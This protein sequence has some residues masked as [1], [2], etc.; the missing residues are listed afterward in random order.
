MTSAD[1]PLGMTL[2]QQAGWNQ[3]RAD[4]CRFLTLGPGGCFA[5]ELNGRPVGTVSTCILGGV[6]WIGMLLVSV[7]VRGRGVG[8]QLMRHALNHLTDRQVTSI[9]LDATPLGQPIYE[10]LGFQPQYTLSRFAGKPQSRTSQSRAQRM[11]EQHERAV[12]ELDAGVV[13]YDR[14]RL[15]N[16]LHREATG[17]LVLMDQERLSGY[18]LM[19]A[20]RIATQVGPAVAT[21]RSSG[22][23]L[24]AQALHQ[25]S[26]SEVFVDIPCIN[27]PATNFALRAGLRPVRDLL[28]MCRGRQVIE[29]T[30]CLWASSGPEKG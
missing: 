10:K 3:T 16:E 11:R 21:S 19:R 27:E 25:L 23:D 2:N 9:R 14:R 29:Q 18:L 5:G 4:W 7:S 15:L 8:T 26:G 13:G 28:R 12:A 30:E 1:I 22:Q 17:R 20:G 24:F 6:G